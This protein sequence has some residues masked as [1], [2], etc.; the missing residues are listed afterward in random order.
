LYAVKRGDEWIV[1]MVSL[2]AFVLEKKDHIVLYYSN[3]TKL[4]KKIAVTPG[5]A[6]INQ[7]FTVKVT[8]TEWDWEKN[9]ERVQS[10][11]G[12][13]VSVGGQSVVTN[14]KGVAAFSG[15]TN[16]IYDVVVTGYTEGSTPSVVKTSQKLVVAK[17]L[18]R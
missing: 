1:P 11:A 6:L 8:T 9:E 7:P 16:G 15:L 3:G 12:V 4:V 10:A 5:V 17:P 2:D 14:D 18:K 13:T